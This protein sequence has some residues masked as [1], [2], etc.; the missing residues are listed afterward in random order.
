MKRNLAQDVGG[1]VSD[2]GSVGVAIARHTIYAAYST[3]IVAYN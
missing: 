3:W 1:P 2:T